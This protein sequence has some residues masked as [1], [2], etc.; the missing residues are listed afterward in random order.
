MP[1]PSKSHV[2][3]FPVY[4]L[5]F[6]PSSFRVV[7]GGGG[8]S[9]RNGVKNAVLVYQIDPVTLDVKP[10]TDHQLEKGEDACMSL[11][12]HPKD[13]VIVAAA[14]C[15]ED[16]IAGGLNK[17]CR[18]FCLKDNNTS[19]QQ[20]KA[21]DSI[22]ETSPDTYQ[23]VTRFSADGKLLASGLT[24]GKLK[25]YS[26]PS[27]SLVEELTHPSDVIDIHFG[28]ENKVVS[29]SS[30]K[31]IVTSI[32]KAEQLCALDKPVFDENQ[33]AE[34][35]GAR[36]AAS[37]ANEVLLVIANAKNKKRSCLYKYT[38]GKE[39]KLLGSK[40]LAPRPVTT[41]DIS[42][43]GELLAYATSDCG[44]TVLSTRTMKVLH[45]MPNAHGFPVTSLSFSPDSNIIASGSADTT[46]RL[47][48]LPPKSSGV[49]SILLL[50]L[51]IFGAILAVYLGHE[52]SQ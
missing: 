36:F 11:A 31:L 51:A 23:K 9:G 50:L 32:G 17:N 8:G 2:V 18:I 22:G 5:S 6:T 28:P 42:P 20:A 52:F 15:T 7:L 46:C 13:K 1:P 43:N 10:L 39:C 24:N 34:F 14:N 27:C 38:V 30:Q 25:V 19:I 35:R 16:E 12:V 4:S 33:P 47:A 21:F 29:V 49:S 44:I 45:T 48:V 26:W 41:F 3:G 40:V 37:E